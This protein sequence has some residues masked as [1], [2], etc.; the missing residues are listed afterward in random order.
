MP[1][2]L[3]VV[4]RWLVLPRAVIPQLALPLFIVGI[5]LAEAT[6]FFG[7]FIFPEH[8]QALVLTSALGIFQ[9]IPLF[10]RRFYP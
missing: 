4:V 8:K 5:A 1:V 3:S 7:L 2:V 9:F 10:A 6:C